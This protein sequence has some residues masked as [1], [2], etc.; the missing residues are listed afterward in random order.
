MKISLMKKLSLAFLLTAIV[1][2]IAAGLIS[3]YMIDKKFN[4]YLI[5]QQKS[6]E[7]KIATMINSLYKEKG[8]FI[9]IDEEEI[10]RYASAEKLYIQ[11]KDNSGKVLLT[12]NKL[13]TTKSAMM[14]SM[15]GGMM[16]RYSENN[17]EYTEDKYLLKKNNK[18]LGIITFGYYNSSY[19]NSS[20]QSF[21]MT[22]N[23]SFMISFLVALAFS[24]I[25][26][27]FFSK[28]I[29]APLIK[30][31]Q[32]SN[33]MRAGELECRAQV[34]SK[35]KEISDLATSIN[36]L[37]DTLQKQELLRKRMTSDIAHEL[38]TPLTNLKSHIEALLDKVW[39][40]TDEVLE[41][42]HEEIERLIKLVNGLN[43]MAKLEQ[44]KVI[45]NKSKFNISQELEKIINSFEP[46]YKNIGLNIYS[47]ITP[48]IEISLD[49]DK[50]NQVMYN[51]LSNALKYSKENGEVLVTLKSLEANIIIEVKDNGIGISKK[52]LP[53]IF[54]RFYR[55]DESRDKNTGG[56]GIG[57]T[58]VKNIVE[59]HKGTITVSS[60]LGEGSTFVITFKKLIQ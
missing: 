32:T 54:E 27:I 16:K 42:F 21:I 14:H 49:K 11:I 8:G 23:H 34:N 24:L 7:D 5:S 26:S 51:L 60:S 44:A 9:S 47:R 45:L 38:R 48:N 20:A 4:S 3:N 35:T 53:F 29:S 56:S 1:A 40:P 33:K 30:I 15:M 22:L 41:G 59:A 39:E 17:G 6:K 13:P 25:I 31:T 18:K 10:V 46:L 37:A 2:I 12:A 36:Y 19:F 52:D 50:F 58:I 43:N 57:L 55:T 28:Q